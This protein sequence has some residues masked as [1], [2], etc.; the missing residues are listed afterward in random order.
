MSTR[1]NTNSTAFEAARNLSMNSDAVSKNIQ[2]LSSGLRINSAADDAAG[3]VISQSM[4]AQVK[5]YDQAT[6]NTNDA[7]NEV[8]TAEGALNET[9]S[10][11]MNVR[12][13]VLHAANSGAN[14][15][16]AVGAD[17]AAIQQAVD[18]IDRIAKTTQFNNKNLLQGDGSAASGTAST[19]TFQIGSNGGQTVSVTINDSRSSNLGVVASGSTYAGVG[20]TTGTFA[21]AHSLA[22]LGSSSTASIDVS[23]TTASNSTGDFAQQ[24]LAIVD[25]AISDVSTTRA[26]L[27]AIQSNELQSNVRS[28]GV[29]QQN[30]AASQSTIQDTDLSSEIVNFTKNQILVQAGTSALAQ[31][32]QAPQAIL[33][34]LQ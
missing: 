31:A 19:L 2:R 28:L 15:S 12:Q 9:Q 27:G 5:G 13:L 24:A 30:I 34:L 1:I 14:D 26:N 17:K 22:D 11:L 23:S 10:L 21:A 6:R 25:K 7:I 18:S 33:K 20:G 3:L 16:T 8:K 32:N 29:A 4:N